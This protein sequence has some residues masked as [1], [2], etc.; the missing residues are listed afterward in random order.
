M[1]I[2]MYR[3][4]ESRIIHFS[5]DLQSFPWQMIFLLLFSLLL[6]EGYFIDNKKIQK[7]IIIP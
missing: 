7:S 5:K 3:R 6:C 4:F 1:D 2:K